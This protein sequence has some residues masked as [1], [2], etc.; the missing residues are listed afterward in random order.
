MNRLW[1]VPLVLSFL[2]STSHAEPAGCPPGAVLFVD[3]DEGEAPQAK[4]FHGAKRAEGRYGSA[5]E[6]STALQYAEVE[7]SRKLDGV[8]SITVG[9]WFFPRRS[10]EQSFF[11]RGLPQTA[12]GGERMFRPADDWVNFVLGTDS[13]GFLLATA[14]GNGRMPFPYVTLN[15]V[16]IGSWS[17][18]VLVKDREGHQK[19]YRNGRLVHTDRDSAHATGR[20][21]FRDTAGGEPVRLMMPMGGWIGEVWVVGRELTDEEVRRDFESK[22]DKYHPALPAEPVALRD[23]DA[24]PRSGLWKSPVTAATW[25]KERERILGGVAK[26]F[27]PMP[28]EKPPPDAKVVSEHDCGTYVRRKVSIQVQPGERMPAYLLIP[29]DLKGKAPAVVCFYGTTSGA[30]KETTVGLSGGKPG[31]RPEKNRDYAVWMAEAGFVAFAGDYLRDGERLPPSGRPYDTTDFYEKFPDWSIH[32]KDAWD[33]MRAIDYLQSLDFVDP[34]RIGMLGHSYGG[35]ST[36][37]TAALDPRIKAA[38]A[39]GPVSDFIHHGMHWAVPRGGGNSQSLPAMRAF[40]LDPT[41]PAPVTF[42]EFTS[43]IAPRPLLVGQAVGER[44]PMEE[45]NHAAVKRVYDALGAPEKVRYVW[46]AGDH[47]FPPPMREAAVEWLRRW[48]VPTKN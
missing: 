27:G 29:K 10:G 11:S 6:F 23:M 38:V 31:S 24:Y 48:L 35:H 44:R 5:L 30:G 8:D 42:Y 39:N 32:G 7:L 25:P 12:P 40:V 28:S 21:P 34:D 43:L 19:F 33:T 41:L 18:L 16:P 14:N 3:F 1:F 45:E 36:I 2:A 9:G 26:V 46:T 20:R 17:Q 47:D 37:F 4:L 15:D 13:H 22:K